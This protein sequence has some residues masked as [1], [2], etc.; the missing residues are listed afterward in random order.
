MANFFPPTVTGIDQSVDIGRSLTADSLFDYFDFDGNPADRYRFFDGG[1]GGETGYF[2]VRG[3]QQ[4]AL[5]WFEVAASDLGTV[6][7][8]AGSEVQNETLNI[9]ARDGLNWSEP[10]VARIQT[11]EPNFLPPTVETNDVSVLGSE[12]IVGSTM[13]LASDPDGD[14]VVRYRVRD[15][16]RNGN[17]GAFWLN[18]VKQKQGDW[19]EF[20]A[21][22]Y[23]AHKSG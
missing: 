8:Y 22:A 20:T 21:V 2:T 13:F 18:N 16:K 6:R 23:L 7:Y 10:G 11:E 17:S 3:V 4:N 14:E 19:F 9:L 15:Q 12:V 5:Q 1:F